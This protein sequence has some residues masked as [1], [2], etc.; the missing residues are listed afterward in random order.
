MDIAAIVGLG[1]NLNSFRSVPEEHTITSTTSKTWAI[2]EPFSTS[3]ILPLAPTRN[4]TN[5]T[6]RRGKRKNDCFYPSYLYNYNGRQ[7]RSTPVVATFSHEIRARQHPLAQ[8]LQTYTAT[9]L[10]DRRISVPFVLRNILRVE[11]QLRKDEIHIRAGGDLHEVD[12]ENQ[13]SQQSLSDEPS[14][15]GQGRVRRRFINPPASSIHRLHSLP[16]QGRFHSVRPAAAQHRPGIAHADHQR[17]GHFLRGNQG[18]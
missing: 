4:T 1:D 11:R 7:S 3:S 15:D 8:K 18:R 12:A 13:S 14:R 2:S 16:Q 17:L 5:S 9:P 6:H 10:P